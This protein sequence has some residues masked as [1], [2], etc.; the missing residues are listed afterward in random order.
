[1]TPIVGMFEYKDKIKHLLYLQ[2]LL[3]S[4]EA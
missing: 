2:I 4:Y 3:C 1:M